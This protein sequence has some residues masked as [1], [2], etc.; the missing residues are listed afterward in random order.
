MANDENIINHK[1][2]DMTA[3]RQREIASMGGKASQEARRRRKT[4]RE[5]LEIMLEKIIKDKAGNDTTIQNA[6]TGALLMKANKGDVR[7]YEVI[8]DTIGEKPVEKQ[9]IVAKITPTQAD[10]FESLVKSMMD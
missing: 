2:N 3:E 6:I 8:R 10:E 4:M 9:E 7:A 5:E 1:F